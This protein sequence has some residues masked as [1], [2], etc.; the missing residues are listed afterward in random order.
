MY[1]CGG[2]EFTTGD[3]T[4]GAGGSS[5]ASGGSGATAGGG[6]SG[7]GA[8][9]GTGGGGGGSGG[10]GGD[11]GNAGNGGSAGAGACAA[12]CGAAA[13]CE[14]EICVL[15]TG[16]S[17]AESPVLDELFVYWAD[18]GQ[19]MKTA[20]T[21]ATPPVAL[22]DLGGPGNFE[23]VAL[24]ADH[25]YATDR[26]TGVA[27]RVKKTG[28]TYVSFATG[29]VDAAGIAVDETHAYFVDKGAGKILRSPKDASDASG[30]Q[31]FASGLGSP[32]AI[33]V[34]ATHV[35]WT[36]AAGVYTCPKGASCAAPEPIDT[37]LLP[38]AESHITLGD[39]R[40]LWTTKNGVAA[41]PQNGTG[42]GAALASGLASIDGL[43]FGENVYFCSPPAGIVY[44]LPPNG[45]TPA[46]LIENQDSPRGV[47]V[48]DS[49]VYWVTS[50]PSSPTGTVR[51]MQ[52]AQ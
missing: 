39:T 52:L 2:D 9:A 15:A 8:S 51:K 31:V 4:G 30:L 34:S 47:A 1:A 19:V 24:D 50:P 33:A 40:V 37:T 5:A 14:G 32:A 49:F 38:D 36:A 42:D 22:V 7:A 17:G 13:H 11:A 28:G 35:F 46:P 48:D 26:G 41:A 6:A 27:L 43:F 45:G 29:L 44:R 20:K 23:F 21:G 12:W 10:L 25:V 3:G 18:P 16:Q